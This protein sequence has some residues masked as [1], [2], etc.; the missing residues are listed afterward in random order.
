MMTMM[1]IKIAALPHIMAFCEIV[2]RRSHGLWGD[3]AEGQRVDTLEASRGKGREQ[4]P[5]SGQ[6]LHHRKGSPPRRAK[7]DNKLIKI[8]I[9]SAS[10]KII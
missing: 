6:F 8:T 7:N 1:M 2:G 5:E 10:R 9:A 3:E 4:M